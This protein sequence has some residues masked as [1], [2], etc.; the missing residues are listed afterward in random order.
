M[1]RSAPRILAALVIVAAICV[2][3]LVMRRSE[4]PSPATAPT[5]DARADGGGA[6][7]AAAPP[8]PAAALP[9]P[10]KDRAAALDGGAAVATG[11]ARGT[12]VIRGAWGSGPGQ[13]GRKRD[14]ESNPEAPMAMAAGA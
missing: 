11:K 10:T 12:V 4:A 1:A 7:H 2:V 3:A 5:V 8:A 13:F 6:V 14:P 9:P